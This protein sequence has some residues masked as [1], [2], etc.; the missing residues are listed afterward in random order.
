MKRFLGI[1]LASAILLPIASNTAMAANTVDDSSLVT[2]KA[3]PG[4]LRVIAD[5]VDLGKLTIGQDIDYV[6]GAVKVLDNTGGN[7]W[8]LGVKSNN[9]ATINKSLVEMVS[10]DNIGIYITDETSQ[11]MAGESQLA[12]HEMT[13]EYSAEWGVAPEVG[14]VNND[15]TWTL[16]PSLA[17]PMA[18]QIQ[19][20]Y[21]FGFNNISAPFGMHSLLNERYEQKNYPYG[22][23]LDGP[24]M[25]GMIDE[26]NEVNLT[27]NMEDFYYTDDYIV[28]DNVPFAMEQ[29]SNHRAQ[30]NMPAPKTDGDVQW[31]ITPSMN[32]I[33]IAH[34]T[35][36]PEIY[37][38]FNPEEPAGYID[39]TIVF[40]NPM[41]P[42]MDLVTT[43]NLE[44]EFSYPTKMVF[45][46][47]ST[48]EFTLKLHFVGDP[49][50]ESQVPEL[51]GN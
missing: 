49:V 10:I 27:V 6:T 26:N 12:E 23:L 43:S 29:L 42:V 30:N 15:L 38:W 1:A 25:T 3:T 46:D 36:L 16:T 24:G 32:N 31:V 44:R 35:E 5:D 39:G 17:K 37:D 34:Q 13:A 45:N 18:Q 22:M 28:E 33:N 14:N 2:G 47:G 7:G 9:Y 11:I 4:T 51:N 48:L 20:S 50:H 41:Y 40:N 19:E 21:V 8:E